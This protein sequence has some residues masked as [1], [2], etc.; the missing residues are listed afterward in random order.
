MTTIVGNS[1]YFHQNLVNF[2]QS[3]KFL[4]QLEEPAPAV[5][6]L[7]SFVSFQVD[8]LLLSLLQLK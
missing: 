2:S 1:K 4:M 5:G 3:F 8:Y 6:P 7:V